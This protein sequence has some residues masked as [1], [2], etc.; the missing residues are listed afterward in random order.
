MDF[1][2]VFFFPQSFFHKYIE[3]N[4]YS[5]IIGL[6]DGSRNLSKIK[7]E[8]QTKNAYNDQEIYPF[9]PHIFRFKYAR[10]RHLR[11]KLFPNWFL[12]GHL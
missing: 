10:C 5:L 2:P 1:L 9:S 7:I 11:F 12:H 4:N 6:G 3:H 8:T